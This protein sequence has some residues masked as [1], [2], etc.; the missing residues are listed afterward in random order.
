MGRRR[1]SELGQPRRLGAPPCVATGRASDSSSTPTHRE[2]RTCCVS[3]VPFSASSRIS[4]RCDLGDLLRERLERFGQPEEG[5]NVPTK[6]DV[7]SGSSR[8][9]CEDPTDVLALGLVDLVGTWGVV[10]RAARR[11]RARRRPVVAPSAMLH[12]CAEV[13]HATVFEGVPTGKGFVREPPLFA[14]GPVNSCAQAVVQEC[15]K[16]RK[17]ARAIPGSRRQGVWKETRT[18]VWLPG[19]VNERESVASVGRP[20][21][22]SPRQ[23][24]PSAAESK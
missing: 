6:C 1:Q 5:A 14:D 4:L 18:S 16:G 22:V 24:R 20:G 3:K 8:T 15:A 11:V 12:R 2:V 7:S 10:A 23:A 9:V 19:S 13:E 21:G 17:R